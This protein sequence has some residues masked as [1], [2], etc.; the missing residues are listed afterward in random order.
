MREFLEMYRGKIDTIGFTAE[1]PSRQKLYMRMMKRLL[2]DWDI[3]TYNAGSG[4]GFTVIAPDNLNE[5]KKIARYNG[6]IM[7]YAFNDSKLK[8]KAYDIATKTPLA[9][10]EFVKEDKELY[11]QD[12]WVN[13]EYRNRGI[14]KSMYDYLKSEGYVIN[15]SHDQTNAGSRFWDKH[16]GEDSYVWEEA[17]DEMLLPALHSSNV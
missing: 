15:R 1:E 11:P 6:L 5:D 12:L 2:P 7:G 14:A 8:I 13:D 10:V 9:F 4:L 3:H 17:L 16:R